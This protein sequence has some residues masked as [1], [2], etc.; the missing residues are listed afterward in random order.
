[1]CNNALKIGLQFFIG[2]IM[3]LISMSE[4]TMSNC[5][6][7]S[8]LV[9]EAGRHTRI[10]DE[11]ESQEVGNIWETMS[12]AGLIGHYNGIPFIVNPM[13]EQTKRE[14]GK[15]KSGSFMTKTGKWTNIHNMVD[16]VANKKA[17]QEEEALHQRNPELYERPHLYANKDRKNK[18][19]P[20]MHR[21]LSDL[22]MKYQADR[23]SV[24][25]SNRVID[26]VEVWNDSIVPLDS[27]HW[28]P[29]DHYD[30]EYDDRKTQGIEKVCPCCGSNQIIFTAT[31]D[32]LIHECAVKRSP[33]RIGKTDYV[34]SLDGAHEKTYHIYV[35]KGTGREFSEY[36]A[37][38]EC[39][40]SREWVWFNALNQEVTVPTGEDHEYK[41][42][43]MHEPVEDVTEAEDHNWVTNFWKIDGT[44]IWKLKED[45]V[46]EL[47][48]D[49]TNDGDYEVDVIKHA[50]RLRLDELGRKQLKE[51]SW[52]ERKYLHKVED[53]NIQ[54]YEEISIDDI[55]DEVL[56]DKI[57]EVLGIEEEL[58]DYT[59]SDDV[60]VWM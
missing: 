59:V 18:W 32:K 23:Y 49:T 33:W 57:N 12:K 36:E 28:I 48:E 26:T 31:K 34:S 22:Y 20:V 3:N 5:T 55:D 16:V 53:T 45:E 6:D 46:R 17:L 44:P 21:V 9:S 11:K 15:Y 25:H 30:P 19:Y 40:K 39:N 35:E 56:T 43:V 42:W 50:L 4:T 51:E 27:T 24:T 1:M 41:V 38:S 29:L 54:V 13:M 52:Q 2:V 14:D 7:N 10:R 47:L 60:A 8:C 37:L 58:D